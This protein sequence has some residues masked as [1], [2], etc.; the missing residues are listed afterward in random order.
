[1]SVR[2]R[3]ERG[4]VNFRQ[5][6]L[7]IYLCLICSSGVAGQVSPATSS[8][9]STRPAQLAYLAQAEQIARLLDNRR[10]SPYLPSPRAAALRDVA[11][12]YA[13]AGDSEAALA[14]AEEFSEEKKETQYIFMTLAGKSIDD[15]DIAQAVEFAKKAEDPAVTRAVAV[16][17]SRKDMPQAM[18]IAEGLSEPYRSRA[19]GGIVRSAVLQDKMDAAA[20]AFGRMTDDEAKARAEKWITAARIAASNNPT[21]AMEAMKVDAAQIAEPLKDLLESKANAFDFER[22]KAILGLLSSAD[23]KSQGYLCIAEGFLKKG[24]K[25]QCQAAI[26]EAL[27]KADEVQSQNS[28]EEPAIVAMRLASIYLKAA[29]LQLQAG[30]HDEAFRLAKFVQDQGK[31]DSLGFITGM[32]SQSVAGILIAAGKIDEAAKMLTEDGRII[33]ENLSMLVI[34]HVEAGEVEQANVLIESATSPEVKTRLL[35]AAAQAST[36]PSSAKR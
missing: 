32:T 27:T 23:G 26:R 7:V 6:P 14:I 34:A 21:K 15:G 11:I 2:L 5:M 1:M 25:Q 31:Q 30:D 4:Y 24:D 19:F 12:G 9:P 18:K 13:Q 22:A 35:L 29:L 36:K 28:N 16:W 17:A 20:Q 33:P 3:R 8:A 10:E